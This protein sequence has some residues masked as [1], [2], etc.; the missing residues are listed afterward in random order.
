MWE[1]GD[2]ARIAALITGIGRDLV[3][4]AQVRPGQ[5]VLDVAAGTGNAAVPAAL[6]GADVTA[7]DVTPRLLDDGRRAAGDLPITWIPGDATALPFA[8][9]AFDVVLSAVGAMFAADHAA[10]ARELTRACRPG[11]LVAL[12]NWTPEGAVGRFFG[13]LARYAAA[14]PD[15]PSPTRWGDPEYVRALFGGLPVECARRHV[16]YGFTG[17]PAELAALYRE[18]FAPVIV[19]RAALADDGERA[20]FDRELVDLLAAECVAG[21]WRFEWLLVTVR[22]PGGASRGG[23]RSTSGTGRS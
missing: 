15:G 3:A 18:A 12:A 21:R 2:Y 22:L 5:R 16:E 19:T 23:G 14:P 8:D 17:T 20:A 9:G 10:A 7:L 13:L 1:L 4:A 6:A 11:G